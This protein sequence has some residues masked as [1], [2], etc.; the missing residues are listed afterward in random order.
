[1][2]LVDTTIVVDPS[3]IIVSSVG[4]SGGISVSQVVEQIEVT[5][6]AGIRGPKGESGLTVEVEVDLVL[7][8]QLAK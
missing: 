1:V 6:A 7:L 2:A 4:A 3:N 5:G 8:Y